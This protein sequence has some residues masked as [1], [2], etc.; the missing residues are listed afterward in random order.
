MTRERLHLGA[1]GEEQAALYLRRQGLKILARNHKTPLGEIDI[2][3]RNRREIIFVEVKTRRSQAFGS[4]AEAVGS[5]KQHQILKAAQVY[6]AA[7]RSRLQP[8]F[9]VIA[10]I[11]D[12]MGPAQIEHITAAFGLPES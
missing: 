3:A 5:R 10:I 6:L 2:I 4:P 1:W 9:D 11:G 7:N 12:G 8:R